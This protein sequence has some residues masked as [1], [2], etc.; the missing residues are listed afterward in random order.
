MAE[1]RIALYIYIYIYIYIST[2]L[3]N[4]VKTIKG[5]IHNASSTKHIKT[6]NLPVMEMIENKVTEYLV[7]N[8]IRDG[9]VFGVLW[10]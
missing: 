7:T 9:D 5:C 3:T 10:T 1:T 6:N 8:R 4:R 2:N